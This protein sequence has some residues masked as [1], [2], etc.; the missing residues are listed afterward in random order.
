MI[1]HREVKSK[2]PETSGKKTNHTQTHMNFE[3]LMNIKI[4][5]EHIELN[6]S[7]VAKTIPLPGPSFRGAKWMGPRVPFFA[8]P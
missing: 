1:L 8:T 6:Q 2:N 4:R 3:L 5:I 7:T